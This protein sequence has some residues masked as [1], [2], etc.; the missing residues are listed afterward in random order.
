MNYLTI[1]L[2]GTTVLFGVAFYIS[3]KVAMKKSKEMKM[4]REAVENQ[5]KIIK[6]FQ[7]ADYEARQ[8]KEKLGKGSTADRVNAS[9]AVLRDNED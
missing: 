7:E 4:L 6:Q 8:Q 3:L 5:K 1:S 2:I 9:I